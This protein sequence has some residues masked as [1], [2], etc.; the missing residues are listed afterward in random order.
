MPDGIPAEQAVA[1]L[2]KVGGHRQRK[3]A[4]VLRYHHNTTDSSDLPTNLFKPNAGLQS[5]LMK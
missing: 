4:P 1:E 2:E 5:L 3:Q